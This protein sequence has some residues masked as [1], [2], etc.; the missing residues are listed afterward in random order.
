LLVELLGAKLAVEVEGVEQT[1][2]ELPG[3]RRL[4]GQRWGLD[5]CIRLLGRH[6]LSL[7]PGRTG[8]AATATSTPPAT[9]PAASTLAS[10]FASTVASTFASTFTSTGASLP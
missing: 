10:T 6:R 3:H 1:L 7:P 5:L 4:F 9:S 2:E 8:L